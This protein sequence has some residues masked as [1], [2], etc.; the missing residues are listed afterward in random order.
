MHELYN[1]GQMTW[2]SCFHQPVPPASCPNHRAVLK[3]KVRERTHRECK[4]E[5]STHLPQV[6]KCSWQLEIAEPRKITEIKPLS[7]SV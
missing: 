7:L 2:F 6:L 5:F 1:L 4:K 3:M